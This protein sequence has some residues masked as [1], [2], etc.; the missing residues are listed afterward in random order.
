MTD[1]TGYEIVTSMRELDGVSARPKLD[2]DKNLLIPMGIVSDH[3]R[4]IYM[5][6]PREL[7]IEMVK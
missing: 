3:L 6:I 5:K 4:I 7:I 1:G 2:E